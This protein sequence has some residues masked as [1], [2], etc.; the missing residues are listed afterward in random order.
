MMDRVKQISKF[1]NYSPKTTAVRGKHKEI[2]PRLQIHKV[3]G[4][5][6]HKLDFAH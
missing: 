1:F 2:Q 3:I 6:P 5:L 4:C